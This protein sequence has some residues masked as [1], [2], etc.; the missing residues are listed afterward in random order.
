M[1]EMYQDCQD[2]LGKTSGHG[3]ETCLHPAVNFLRLLA[4]MGV[5]SAMIVLFIRATIKSA[6]KA[7]SDLS[8]IGKIGFS[9]LQFNSMAL[10]FDYEFPPMVDMFL[11]IQEQPATIANGVMSVDCF[12][13]DSSSNM[14]SLYVKSI[15]YLV[16]PIAIAIICGVVFWKYRK[17]QPSEHEVDHSV[18]RKVQQLATLSRMDL[19]EDSK[20]RAYV[21]AWNHY[22]TA[23]IVTIFI[24]HPSIVQITFAMFN[25]MEL[26]ANEDDWY[27]VEDMGVSCRTSTHLCFQLLV[28][29]PM[30]IF[31]VM[32]LPLFVLWR[33]YQNRDELTKSFDQINSGMYLIL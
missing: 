1:T 12:V 11:R 31:Y 33:L 29:G 4:V 16:A 13:K 14:S 15:C 20:A 18:P 6:M 2:G 19:P 28:A 27:L 30:M 10:Q 32:G 7:K 21:N 23:F 9:F 8:T 3:C 24:I 25:C 26:G 5:V 17:I 22:I